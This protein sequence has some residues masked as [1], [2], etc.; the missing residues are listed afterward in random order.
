MKSP[1]ENF[2]KADF[3]IVIAGLVILVVLILATLGVNKFL[4]KSPVL[5][6]QNINF[7]VFFRGIT[8][9]DKVSPFKPGEDTFITIRNVPYTKLKITDVQVERRRI[10]LETNKKGDYQPVEDISLPCLYDFTVTVQDKAKITD[11][12]AVVGGN[13]VKMGIPVILEGKNYKF[14]GV[15]SNVQYE[16]QEQTQKNPTEQNTSEETAE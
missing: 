2:K 16:Q 7:T 5:E 11:D 12:G 1:F 8:I 4:K 13:K 15:I 6:E 14:N 10:L 9:T 3:A